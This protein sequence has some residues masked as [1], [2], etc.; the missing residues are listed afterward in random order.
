MRHANTNAAIAYVEAHAPLRG[1]VLGRKRVAGVVNLSMLELN[2]AVVI[3]KEELA[4]RV[5]P[6]LRRDFRW[7][8]LLM[9]PFVS[10][11]IFL[12]HE[13]HELTE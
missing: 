5:I 3:S 7:Y 8:E 9:M 13:W 10:R 2:M 1:I 12:V 4:R 6:M 11:C